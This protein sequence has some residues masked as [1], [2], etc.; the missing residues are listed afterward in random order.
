MRVSQSTIYGNVLNIR[1]AS[2]AYLCL[3]DDSEAE[4]RFFARMQHAYV[5]APKLSHTSGGTGG[6]PASQRRRIQGRP[7]RDCLGLH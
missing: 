5:L 7:A 2:A 3:C 6:A 1:G 4:P